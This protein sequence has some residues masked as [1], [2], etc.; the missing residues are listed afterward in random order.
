MYIFFLLYHR[1]LSMS[2]WKTILH[3]WIPNINSKG[4]NQL[5]VSLSSTWPPLS[6]SPWPPPAPAL[7]L[8]R[9]SG[10]LTIVTVAS[11]LSCQRSYFEDDW[12]EP[13]IWLLCVHGKPPPYSPGNIWSTDCK[14]PEFEMFISWLAFIFFQL[15][16]GLRLK[17]AH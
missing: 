10:L 11:L 1:H 13:A 4:K 12:L 9:P 5:Q 7:Y 6:V 14:A 17:L 3:L 15:S 2:I 8:S 16:K